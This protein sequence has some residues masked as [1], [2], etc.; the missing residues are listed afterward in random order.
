MLP[1]A[2]SPPR[3]RRTRARAA[4]SAGRRCAARGEGEGL[5]RPA[6]AGRGRGRG[7]GGAARLP[8]ARP[9]LL[10]A[11][12]RRGR[13]GRK[14]GARSPRPQPAAPPGGP[15]AETRTPPRALD[16]R[17]SGAPAAGRAP[18]GLFSEASGSQR[19]RRPRPWWAWG[20][21]QG[22]RALD[23]ESTF[24]R[25]SSARGPRAAPLSIPPSFQVSVGQVLAEMS[26]SLSKSF[27]NSHPLGGRRKKKKDYYVLGWAYVP[28]LHDLRY[29]SPN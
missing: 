19:G 4:G 8:R 9:R 15:P 14:G 13:P 1:A 28:C 25:G 29:E 26:D 5:G 17:L 21:G 27:I 18:R 12:P 2:R 10:P 16:P 7:R 6:A 20:N 22:L 11:R 23:G 3:G 24:H